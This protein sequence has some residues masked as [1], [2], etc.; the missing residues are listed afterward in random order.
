MS[1]D[2][3]QANAALEVAA[4]LATTLALLPAEWGTFGGVIGSVLAQVFSGLASDRQI[5]RL[6]E[7]VE[8]LVEEVRIHTGVHEEYVQSEDFE[9]LVDQAL[10]QSAGERH[11]RK[12]EMYARF[13]AGLATSEPAPYDERRQQLRTLDELQLRH[14]EPLAVL[15]FASDHEQAPSLSSDMQLEARLLERGGGDW[16]YAN[17]EILDQL[18]AMG[19]ARY[20]TRQGKLKIREGRRTGPEIEGGRLTAVPR[21]TAYGKRFFLFVSAEDGG[22]ED[23]LMSVDL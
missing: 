21:I 1:Q 4:G 14:I 15:L 9:D 11:Q 12:R 16:M 8:R 19:L 10:R 20:M 5:R 13:I 17:Y 3:E 18:V 6:H 23:R 7:T 2:D 22:A